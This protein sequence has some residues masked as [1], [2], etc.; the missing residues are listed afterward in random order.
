ITTV[1][2]AAVVIDQFTLVDPVSDQVFSRPRG[3]TGDRDLVTTQDLPATQNPTTQSPTTQDPTTQQN[4]TAQSPTTT[5]D[6]GPGTNPGFV[7]LGGNDCDPGGG[8]NVP[9][10]STNQQPSPTTGSPQP[11]SSGG[12]TFVYP[13]DGQT[14]SASGAYLFKVHP[15]AGASGYLFG[16]FQNETMVWENY[17]DEGSLSGTE[18]GIHPGTQAHSSIL[19][20]ALQVWVRALVNGQ[21]TDATIISITIT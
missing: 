7:C 2:P 15:T 1:Q 6:T 11:V 4:P 8:P 17:R 21:W 9:A 3:S 5:P 14:L 20:G 18:Y 13:Q 10:P 16:F 19:P 12:P